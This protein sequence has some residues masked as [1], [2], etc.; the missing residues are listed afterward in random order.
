MPEGPEVRRVVD[1]LRAKVKGKQLLTIQS[2]R[3]GK[4]QQELLTKWP[5]VE[6][7]FPSICL[8]IITRGKQLYFFLENGICINSG[9]GMEGHWYIN[10]PGS[11]T[12]C[13]LVFGSVE[14]RFHITETYLYFDDS[15]RFGS[16][17]IVSW[18]DAIRKMMEDYG[19]D[20]LNVKCPQEDIHPTVIN[21]LPKEFFLVPTIE[22]FTISMSEPRRSSMT[23]ATFL[24]THQD[25]FSGVGNWILNETCYFARLHPNRTLG[26]LSKEQIEQLFNAVIAVITAGYQSGGLT[27]G[28]FLDPDKQKGLYQTSVYKRNIDPYGNP[29]TKI[30][31][32]VSGKRSGYVVLSLQS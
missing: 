26:T 32:E 12:D 30:T 8:D 27:H 13:A 25:Y 3:P 18:A 24:L 1:K 23:I 15:R 9:L 11:H 21:N 6:K 17:N 31:L 19:P 5:Y 28:T 2:F 20:F 4:V 16:V 22:T 7:I 29:I 14:G 10:Q